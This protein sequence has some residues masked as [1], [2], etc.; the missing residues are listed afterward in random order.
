MQ[1]RRDIDGLRAVA[2]LSVV[3]CHAGVEVFSGGYVGVD[4]F[5][6]ISGY[7]ITS[8]IIAEKDAGRFSLARFYERRVRRILPALFFMMFIS[9]IVAAVVLAPFSG[10][11]FYRSV[12]ATSLFSSNIL[13]FLESGD[14]FDVSAD[15]KPLLHTWSLGVEEQYYLIFPILMLVLLNGTR[16]YIPL[17]FAVLA[18]AS[19]VVSQQAL[20]NDPT[21][22]FYLLH[23]RGWELAVGALVAYFSAKSGGSWL[24]GEQMRQWG[25]AVGFLLVLFAIF[26]F[27]RGT[28]F[29]GLY[30]LVPVI[31][32][33]MVIAFAAP[34]T[35]IARILSGRVV[36][37]IG[38]MSYSIYL[39]HQ[40]IY[41]FARHL[42]LT[43]LGFAQYFMAICATFVFG[44]LSYRYVERP[45]R[46]DGKVSGKSIAWLAVVCSASF[47]VVGLAGH[48]T[49]GF[50]GFK[51]GAIPESRQEIYVDH[52]LQLQ[53]KSQLEGSVPGASHGRRVLVIG[54]SMAGDFLLAVKAGGGQFPGYD[55]VR[56]SLGGL[57]VND[58][59]R[60]L[61]GAP[62]SDSL[63]KS[64]DGF[65]ALM[66][67]ISVADEVVLANAWTSETAG[68]AFSIAQKIFAFGKPVYVVDAFR[69]FNISDASYYFARSGA[70]VEELAGF[71]RS[72]LLPSS[73]EARQILLEASGR[74]HGVAFIDKLLFFCDDLACNFYDEHSRPLLHDDMHVTAYGAAYYGDALYRAGYFRMPTAASAEASIAVGG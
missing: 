49:V 40:P 50:Q 26:S 74:S 37:G 16:K 47:A 4:V 25:S 45:F 1:Y 48:V 62:P 8:I 13:F 14:Y 41:A 67:E 12:A 64:R 60:V 28:P 33:A 57:C 70:P 24:G 6:V 73:L 58:F 10:R 22:S 59:Y 35:L 21:A 19:F 23:A 2:V 66:A 46:T 68:A 61:D 34:G 51:V 72:R 5:F 55:F 31:G 20:G 71:M 27:D 54:D 9:V 7:L 29:P 44:Y 36:V 17:I 56:G 38:L 3:L 42:T 39:W 65:A 15:L 11:A 69:M 18:V 32:G 63:C 43:E 53:K 30:A 52:F